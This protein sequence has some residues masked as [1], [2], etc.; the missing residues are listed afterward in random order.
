MPFAPI[1]FVSGYGDQT[2]SGVRFVLHATANATE[3]ASVTSAGLAFIEGRPMLST[4]VI[5]AYQRTVGAGAT[6]DPWGMV[7]EGQPGSLLVCAV[8]PTLHLGYGI[9][10]TAYVDRAQKRV[11]GAP[12]RYAAGRRQLAFY[13][14]AET[15]AA[16]VHIE[17]EVANGFPLEQRPQYTLDPEYVIGQ[18]R[19]GQVLAAG[20]GQL[21]VAVRSLQ[22]LDYQRLE[23]LLR[24]AFD[25]SMA[26]DAVLVPTAV[27]DIINGT[28]E[29]AILSELRM[30]RWQGLALLGYSF[31]EDEQEVQ[32]TPPKDMTEHRRHI[33]EFARRVASSGLFAAELAWLKVYGAHVL[34][35]MR[36]E[37]EGA[38]LE[39]E[40]GGQI[41]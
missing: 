35:L 16:R 24:E 18:F 5:E 31:I 19:S 38:V 1:E 32:I 40:E 23:A 15:E 28:V 33:D 22:P 41:L 6:S 13:N 8:P 17:A 3:T 12:L 34:E 2:L 27:R 25:P 14:G 21:S 36:V 20:L 29:A 7:A 26:A 37:L 10:T 11:S 39:S 9:F 4:D 30:M